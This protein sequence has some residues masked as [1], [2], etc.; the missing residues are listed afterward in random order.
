MLGTLDSATLSSRHNIDLRRVKGFSDEMTVLLSHKLAHDPV[1]PASFFNKNLSLF[2]AEIPETSRRR[3]PQVLVLALPVAP[4]DG[5]RQ[6]AVPLL[7]VLGPRGE[8][9]VVE[10]PIVRVPV[11]YAFQLLLLEKGRPK[12]NYL[13]ADLEPR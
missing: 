10:V 7:L 3:L 1:L 5:F 6:S 9:A 13:A 11:Q 4:V 8:V 2:L 12:D